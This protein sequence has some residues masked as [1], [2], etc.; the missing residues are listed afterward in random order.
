MASL[1]Q[2]INNQLDEKQQYNREI[3]DYDAQKQMLISDLWTIFVRGGPCAETSW[4]IKARSGIS[5]TNSDSDSFFAKK[6]FE[7]KRK[8]KKEKT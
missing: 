2:A 1:T 6:T 8:I 7:K 4:F 5:L 3:R